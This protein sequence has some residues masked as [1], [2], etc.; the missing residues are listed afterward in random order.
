AERCH[1]LV[2][3]LFRLVRFGLGSRLLGVGLVASDIE[4]GTGLVLLR[5]AFLP[6][7]VVT[8][9][10]ADCFFALTLHI[11]DS[12]TYCRLGTRLGVAH[13]IG[14][15]C[16]TERTWPRQLTNMTATAKPLYL[17]GSGTWQT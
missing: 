16:Q 15:L 1:L 9:D 5:S 4:F 2:S 13:R 6:E 10:A 3:A 11:L 8:D 17:L 12:A 7:V 14:L